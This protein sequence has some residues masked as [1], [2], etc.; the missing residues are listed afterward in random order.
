MATFK[1]LLDKRNQKNKKDEYNLVIR[2]C[3]GSDVNYL[4]IAKMTEKQYHHVFVKKATDEKSIEFREKCNAYITKCERIIGELK[5]Y[6]KQKF[7]ALFYEK[8]K[9][10]P[11]SLALIGLFEYFIDNCGL[12][13]RTRTHIKMTKLALENYNPGMTVWDITPDFLKKFEKD[14][15]ASGMSQATIDS[16]SRDL[17]RIINYFSNEV[18]LI[19]KNYQ[20]PFGKSGYS[21]KN[22]FPKKLVLTNDEIKSVVEFKDPEKPGLEYSRDIWLLLYRCNGINFVDLLR[23]RWTDIKGDYIIFFRKKT[24]TTRKNNKKEIT[25]PITEK[26]REL[27]DKIGVKD[28]P[29]VLGKLHEGYKEST[30]ENRC[31]KISQKINRDLAVIG[32]KLN[33]SVPLKLK[34]ARDSYATTLMRG[35]ISKDEIG[36][37]LG[38][39][40]SVVTEHYLA[41]LDI[42]KTHQINAVLF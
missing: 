7:R 10:K 9:V 41:S 6:N 22:F 42:E 24:E 34:T 25:V 13:L 39:S 30:F 14:K 19:P 5:P 38:H 23:M 33:L 18:I 17:R 21:I 28:S 26:L 40:N 20:Y 11:E 16:Y 37:M 31:H 2:A 29:F 27:L 12:K 36:S 1:C 32:G 4:N 8:D 3:I 15:M 35:G